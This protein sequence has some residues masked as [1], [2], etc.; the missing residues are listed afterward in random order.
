MLLILVSY[1]IAIRGVYVSVGFG[2]VR[3]VTH[4]PTSKDFELPTHFIP[5]FSVRT[6]SLSFISLNDVVYDN[7]T[8][9]LL[10]SP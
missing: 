7:S 6:F 1:N 2:V 5:T 8:S 3:K 4:T 10:M 9:L